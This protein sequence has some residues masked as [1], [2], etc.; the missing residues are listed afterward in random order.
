MIRP[1]LKSAL[2]EKMTWRSERCFQDYVGGKGVIVRKREGGQKL[3][4]VLWLFEI[5][6]FNIFCFKRFGKRNALKN[7]KFWL[8]F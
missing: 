1:L 8:K 6:T 7:I 5:L 4:Q 2:D 3:L